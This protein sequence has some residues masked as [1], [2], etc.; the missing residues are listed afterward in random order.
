MY[1]SY[2]RDNTVVCV[3]AEKL[4]INAKAILEDSDDDDDNNSNNVYEKRRKE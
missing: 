1:E 2:A 4:L 3:C